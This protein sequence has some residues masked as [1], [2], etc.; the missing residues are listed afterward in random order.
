MLLRNS[1]EKNR[2]FVMVSS[3]QT[4]ILRERK[5]VIMYIIL[6][7]RT[8]KRCGGVSISLHRIQVKKVGKSPVEQQIR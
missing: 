8:S 7:Q 6:G 4:K 3:T 5:S 2:T 1:L